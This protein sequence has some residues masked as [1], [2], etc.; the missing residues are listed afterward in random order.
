MTRRNIE[1]VLLCVAAP[2][3]VLLFAML[4]VNQGLALNATTLG[5]PIG[6]FVA[7][8][9]A[10]LA[11]RKFAP[12]ADPAILPI[13][14][15][16]SGI[17]ICFVERLAPN[18]A[19]NQV[20]WLF[21]GVAFMVLVMALERNHDKVANYKYTL[22]IV[23]FL[24]L[25]SPLV[26]GLGQEI[27][28]SRI[29]LGIG[30][31]SFQ[32][33]EIAKIAIVLFLAG[34]LA[35]NREMLS[36]FTWRVG[37]FNLPDIR[38]LLPLL[39]MW[40]VALVIVVFEKDLGSAL[41]F[42]FLF[43]VML[44]VATGKKFYL[45]VGLGLIAIGGV[46]AYLAFG[47]VQVRVDNWLDPFADA[48]NTGYQLVQ[49]I[50]S[51]ADGDLFGV[52]VGRGL[53]E[54]IPVVESDYIFAAIAEE[55][56]LLGAAGVLLLF[57]CLAIRG[58]VT[59]ARAKSDVSSFVAVGLTTMIVLQAFI[60]VGGVTRLIPLTGLTLPFI[61]QGGSSLLASF[62]AVGFLMRCG[63]EGTGVGSEVASATSSLH[64]NSVLGRV[65]LGKRLTH[66]MIILS[67]LFALLVA[68]LTLIMVVQANYYQNMPGNNHTLAKES[69]TERGTISTYDGVI[70][71]QSV[72]QEDG[73]YERVYPAGNLATHVVGYASTQF[74][75]SGIEAAENDTLKGQQNYASWT[76][77]LNSLAGIGGVGNDVT[78]T[79]NSKIQQAAQDAL[80]GYA[81]ACVVMDPET[82]AV[83]GMASSPTYDAADFAAEIEK[84][85]ANPDGE[86]TLLN[87]AIQTLYAP[88]ST[89]KIVTLATALEDGVASEDTVFSSPG[90]MDIGNAPVTNFNKNSY[91]DITLARATELS[92][93]TVFGQ[94]GVEMGAEKLVDGADKFGFNRKIDFTLNT[95][96]SLMAE[97]DEMT[98]WELAWSAAGEP[99]NP[100]NHPSPAGPQATVLEMALVGCAIANDGAIMNPYLVEGVY[101]A[102]GERSFTA[103]PNK[104]L[105]AVSKET[106]N[107]VKDVL[108]GVVTDGTGT[109]AALPGVEVAGKTG[110]AEKEN[111]NDSW[112]VGMAPAD[113]PR[114]VVAINLELADEG[115]GTERAQNVLRT[116]LQVQ[117]LL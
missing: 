59:A 71:A 41:V 54:Q 37:P 47:H 85:N 109:A 92:S 88:G 29:W 73:T 107:R 93:N 70:L 46:G 5:V 24:L 96:T 86:S 10:H 115:M 106:A 13:V 112:F 61:S 60:I 104:F 8:I 7:F 63:D 34:Y 53:A 16:L 22:M 103:T 81:G 33:G 3:V 40:L 100:Q 31:F 90:T 108:K 76:D 74:G 89:F 91:G 113:N 83:L 98:K 1:L 11:T 56:G 45:V 75:T 102:N 25:L 69:R 55:I 17:G 94:L 32:P 117:G 67:T 79:L 36:V 19:M 28:G 62:I 48:Q 57:L 64:A 30:K 66:A 101:N 78:L 99:V 23:G 18:L 72:Q 50:Y 111:G 82:G 58:F 44:Y 26:P 49:G 6:I 77:V 4:A 80:S 42:F 14:F 38:T 9:I 21:L 15:A 27:Y 43:L 68:N 65:S 84:A 39:L 110:T 51:I 105:Q 95:A 114:V 12:K 35:Q 97:P 52:G 2:I 116:A 87:R 20:M